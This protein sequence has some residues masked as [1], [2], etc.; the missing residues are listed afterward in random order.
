MYVLYPFVIL[1]HYHIDF[2]QVSYNVNYFQIIYLVFPKSRKLLGAGRN[3]N[4]MKTLDLKKFNVHLK[5]QNIDPRN[6]EEEL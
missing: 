3:A 5:G 1:V 2:T 6:E 4:E